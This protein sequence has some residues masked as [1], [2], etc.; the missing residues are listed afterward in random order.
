MR[1]LTFGEWLAAIAGVVLIAD[2]FAPWYGDDT[3]LDAFSVVLG[4]L[5]AT[6]AAGIGTWL[7]TVWQRSV[8]VPVAIE[9]WGSVLTLITLVIVV[10]RLLDPPVDGDV[11]WG[12]WLGLVCVAAIQYGLWRAMRRESRD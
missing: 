11:R 2:L 5:I 6:A 8:A 12:A 3:A 10:V 1:R 9:T 4:F 7:A